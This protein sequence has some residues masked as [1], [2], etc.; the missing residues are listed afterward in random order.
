MVLFPAINHSSLD[1]LS[2]PPPW[3]L[4]AFLPTVLSQLSFPKHFHIILLFFTRGQWSEWDLNKNLQ[5]MDEETDQRGFK[6]LPR[7]IEKPKKEQ[8]SKLRSL[9]FFTQIGGESEA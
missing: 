1:L 6:T 3:P 8:D 2:Y 9:P 4:K 5:Y 7:L